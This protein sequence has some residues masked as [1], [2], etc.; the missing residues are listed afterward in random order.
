MELYSER[1]EKGIDFEIAQGRAEVSKTCE[2]AIES[3]IETIIAGGM[4]IASIVTQPQVT[5]LLQN[6]QTYDQG[7]VF[8]GG[9]VLGYTLAVTL[10]LHGIGG[11][12]SHGMKYLRQ[13]KQL[14]K[15]E[16]EKRDIETNP[17]YH[18]Q[19]KRS[20]KIQR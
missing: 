7:I 18:L 17:F 16:E 5:E 19:K 8:Q 15:L 20:E 1:G 3:V 2:K 12:I 13:R 6:P 4:G 14:R 11:V 10:G 9:V